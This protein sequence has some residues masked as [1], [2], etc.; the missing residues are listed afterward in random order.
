MYWRVQEHT[1]KTLFST[2]H[3][4]MIIIG[5]KW[6]NSYHH[7]L[8]PSVSLALSRAL[9]AV[10]TSHK[11]WQQW[12]NSI[13]DS[14]IGVEEEE[15]AI[16]V[17]SFISK[18][19]V[20]VTDEN[21]VLQ[22]L[23][24]NQL[25][26]RIQPSSRLVDK[27]LQRFEDDWKSALGVFQWAGSQSG[28][29]HTTEA[30]DRMMDIL[31]KMK[32]FEK[33]Y[34][35]VEEMRGADLITLNTV[36]KV[37]RRLAGAGRYEDVVKTFDDLGNFGLEKGVDSMN[38]LLDTLCKERRVERA[39]E[40]FL[41]LKANIPPNAHTFN[42]FVHGWCK[43]GRVDEANWTILEMKGCGIRPC[44]ITYSTILQAYCNKFN[45]R[46]VNELLDEMKAQGCPPNV[47]TYTTLMHSLAKSQQ[48]EEALQIFERM[49]TDGCKLDTLV[50]N[51]LIHILGKA[52]Q[53]NKA[54][55]IFEVEMRLNGIIPSVSTYNTMIAVFC[56]YSL[57]QS[58]LNVL[59]EMENSVTCKPD[60]LT[61]NPLL[62]LYFK[63]GKTDDILH[64][65][66][67]DMIH[68]HH[69]SL[70][71]GTYTLLIH[72]LCRAGKCEWAYHLF[73]EMTSLDIT[74]RYRTCR[75]LLEE[76][77][78]KNMYDFVERIKTYVKQLKDSC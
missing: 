69:L 7:I 68:K 15:N 4:F 43:A 73:E 14:Y 62:K 49:K 47:V 58:A 6:V 41:E 32:Q 28:Y 35:L 13:G 37:M 72:G 29:T 34:S 5:R 8:F 70:G 50:Y 67:H 46:K 52:N 60:L 27:L 17:A 75:V 22:S 57:E 16:K 64:K 56:H 59:R 20:G 65:L 71:L 23:L 19:R 2:R 25:C 51:S 77:E 24:R 66:L 11:G 21:G 31:G 40:I 38:L 74:P 54:I 33:M 1:I 42:I 18:L 61:Y 45:F 12:Q 36:A 39:R 44:V 3:N 55:H 78:D 30:Y 26:C 76:L 10:A 53:L 9:S 63:M 48:Y